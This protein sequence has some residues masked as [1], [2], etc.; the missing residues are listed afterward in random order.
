M[1]EQMSVD[2][3]L[4]ETGVGGRWPV[5]R[6]HQCTKRGG[7]LSPLGT[8]VLVLWRRGGGGRIKSIFSVISLPLL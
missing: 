8:E 2:K 4:L 1:H 6:R 5:N 3:F 7:I